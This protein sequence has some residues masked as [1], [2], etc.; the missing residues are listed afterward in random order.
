LVTRT[1]YV[2]YLNQLKLTRIEE[3]FVLRV[4]EGVTMKPATPCQRT[5]LKKMTYS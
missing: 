5:F 3:A 4:E 1:K 2:K